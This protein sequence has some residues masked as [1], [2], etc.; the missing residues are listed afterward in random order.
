MC[1]KGNNILLFMP[2]RNDT[3]SVLLLKLCKGMLAS[4]MAETDIT[5]LF[6]ALHFFT[7]L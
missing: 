3:K 6:R 1:R 7:F 5:K 4:P 2:N